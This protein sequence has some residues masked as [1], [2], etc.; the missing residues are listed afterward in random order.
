M[1]QLQCDI[2][3]PPIKVEKKNNLEI[4]DEYIGPPTTEQ[5]SALG[6][7]VCVCVFTFV[8]LN[9]TF[10]IKEKKTTIGHRRREITNSY[11]PEELSRIFH[12]RTGRRWPSACEG[13][14]PH[15][16][17][18]L[19]SCLCTF[20]CITSRKQRVVLAI[21]SG[22]LSW[23]SWQTNTGSLASKPSFAIKN[24]EG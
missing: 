5:I 12:G 20:G 1:M 7:C 18:L 6:V 8:S 22:I 10:K 2:S 4:S 21:Q 11:V 3:I 23:R 9:Q 14:R 15:N 16:P 19:T 13:E 17:D 24:G